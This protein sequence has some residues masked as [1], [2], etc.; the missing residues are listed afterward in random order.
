MGSHRRDAGFFGLVATLVERC[1]G[2]SSAAGGDEGAQHQAAAEFV[3]RAV[4]FHQFMD[5]GSAD[6][7]AGL[8]AVRDRL[9]VAGRSD[10][11]AVLEVLA[12]RFTGR[13]LDAPATVGAAGGGPGDG[14]YVGHGTEGRICVG[15]EGG[16]DGRRHAVVQLLLGL[17][18]A[19]GRDEAAPDAE[20]EPTPERLAE[21]RRRARNVVA[22]RLVA[23]GQARRQAEEGLLKDLLDKAREAAEADEEDWW[24]DGTLSPM[25]L[26]SSS[27]D[28]ADGDRGASR[29]GGRGMDELLPKFRSEGV[30]RDSDGEEDGAGV[31]DLRRARVL[32]EAPTALREARAPPGPEAWDAV[33]DSLG[34]AGVPNVGGAAGL[35]EAWGRALDGVVSGEDLARVAR[36]GGLGVASNPNVVL[37][38]LL[39]IEPEPE[40][41]TAGWAR[42]AL[43]LP[44]AA[45]V[46]EILLVL[47]GIPSHGVWA[48]DLSF[49]PGVRVASLSAQSLRRA[50]A[51]FAEGLKR[52]EIVRAFVRE[53]R[54]AGGLHRIH[55]D[56][57]RSRFGI[58][59]GSNLD[60]PLPWSRHTR[61]SPVFQAAGACIGAWLDAND[62]FCA[63]LEAELF[64][65]TPPGDAL[66][67]P[68]GRE[69][70]THTLLT[71][72]KRMHVR[73]AELRVLGSVL[74]QV[75]RAE[76]R[77]FVDDRMVPSWPAT[78]ASMLL[79]GLH[80]ALK[81]A[82]A[83]GDREATRLL[84]RVLRCAGRPYVEQL[85]TW[86]GRG[87]LPTG[88]SDLFVL[89]PDAGRNDGGDRVAWLEGVLFAGDA[90]V[91][92]FLT[93]CVELVIVAGKSVNILRS[94]VDGVEEALGP[95]ERLGLNILDIFWRGL[96]NLEAQAGSLEGGVTESEDVSSAAAHSPVSADAG[97]PSSDLDVDGAMGMAEALDPAFKEMQPWMAS[98]LDIGRS[99]T[100]ASD[101]AWRL[102]GIASHAASFVTTPIDVI[103][104]RVLL[105][106]IR[107][108]CDASVS[109]LRAHLL[110]PGRLIEHL[111]L[112]RAFVLMGAGD[113]WFE[114]G[115]SLFDKLRAGREAA[116]RGDDADVDQRWKDPHA[117]TSLFVDLARR[118]ASASLGD[119]SGPA[120]SEAPRGGLDALQIEIDK[121]PGEQD[122][123]AELDAELH[124]VESGSR[125]T[126]SMF[127]KGIRVTD[128]IRFSYAVPW[129]AH[130]VVNDASMAK[131]TRVARFL[132]QLKHCK[133]VLERI[134]TDS[135]PNTKGRGRGGLSRG[136][137]LLQSRLLTF[138]NAVHEH[139]MSGV[140]GA[141]WV[142]LLDGLTGDG[143]H[144][145]RAQ[146][147][148]DAYL[149]QILRHC[150]LGPDRVSVL[151]A[152]R[153]QRIL[154]VALEL[155]SLC[156][157]SNALGPLRFD[158]GLRK[159]EADFD[160]S[161]SFLLR[162]VTGKV[163]ANPES[164]FAELLMRI[165]FN[166][167]YGKARDDARHATASTITHA[168]AQ[169]SI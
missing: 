18:Y 45:V 99:E 62:A 145:F 44:E 155:E 80:S 98:L 1:T 133:H 105:D 137:L 67:S 118:G 16:L 158:H 141:P 69:G 150:L 157:A 152:G 130:L 52:L 112:L 81:E 63:S 122:L 22:A 128:S 101:E 5:R 17:A 14:R 8:R 160:E 136:V 21:R 108:A 142:E 156:W 46:H 32:A 127:D 19:P 9:V 149:E 113:T 54:G 124:V 96:R 74:D 6:A 28:E 140:L 164:V 75:A 129:P 30:A 111:T 138:T 114:F 10:K 23:E 76:H 123:Q 33:V 104:T 60:S 29:G 43:V 146:A 94:V 89:Q 97:E 58:V 135:D 153:I 143:T 40:E 134:R 7:H 163:R 154:A 116:T 50:V 162:V 151:V 24:S 131:Y 11:A 65:H 165:D 57:S 126:S 95:L 61:Q 2:L 88:S 117:L 91:P 121:D 147:L 48:A 41:E 49:D 56:V 31:E 27:G 120:S 73:L 92:S 66:G 64:F 47:R 107:V 15:D 144:I 59:S 39:S 71:L 36:C 148:H 167:F 85:G 169:G 102:Q 38:L 79:T 100:E 42:G 139:M 87:D 166:G 84:S 110:G 53:H 34:H 115:V 20:Y 12:E 159:L 78:R 26:S 4:R 90:A 37:P 83:R 103:F 109:R 70:E 125:G 93:P 77:I 132:I 51:P 86:L 25:D 3:D 106:P 119:F 55:G 72:S 68:R 168:T 161:N 13:G 35:H 82:L